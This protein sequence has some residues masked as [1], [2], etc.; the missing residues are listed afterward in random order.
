VL[1]ARVTLDTTGLNNG[2]WAL[3]LDGL[4]KSGN[5]EAVLPSDFA[6]APTTVINGSLRINAVP[7][8]STL[9]LI[10]CVTHSDR[11]STTACLAHEARKEQQR[12]ATGRIRFRNQ[13]VGN[14]SEIGQSRTK[15]IPYHALAIRNSCILRHAT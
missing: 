4:P 1:L 15:T 11:Y 5:F 2:N 6:G 3:R 9:A 12:I 8:P 14:D 10:C 13:G 7:E